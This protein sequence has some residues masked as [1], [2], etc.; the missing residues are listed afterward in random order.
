MRQIT[1]WDAVD[2]ARTLTL[3]EMGLREEAKESFKK[4]TLLEEM[5]WRQKSREV[6]L[7]EGDQ[8][9]RFFHKMA[10]AHRRKNR[11]RRIRINGVWFTE[12]Q[13]MKEE[14]LRAFENLLTD[15]G[16]WK[17][18]SNNLS[19]E[20][21]DQEE[22]KDLEKPFT[23]KE[24]FKALADFKGDRAPGPI[25]FPMGFLAFYLGLC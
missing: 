3:E 2:N 7:K 10:N 14:I 13:E 6:W 9:T 24:I 15:S 1:H 25:G 21:I 22:A 12:D 17:L 23:E 16:G 20:R 19:F 5:S 8:N 18:D 4:W 11:I